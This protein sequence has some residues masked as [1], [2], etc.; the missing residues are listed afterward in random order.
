MRAN[1]LDCSTV[2]KWIYGDSNVNADCFRVAHDVLRQPELGGAIVFACAVVAVA[3]LC[4]RW[5]RFG[6]FRAPGVRFVID[7][8]RA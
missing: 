2:S 1:P 7:G 6:S 8:G 3:E 5:R 4:A